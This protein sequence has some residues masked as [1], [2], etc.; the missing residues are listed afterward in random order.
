MSKQNFFIDYVRVKLSI[1][2]TPKN[3]EPNQTPS[4]AV[5]YLRFHATS[6]AIYIRAIIVAIT[7]IKPTLLFYVSSLSQSLCLLSP[8]SLPLSLPLS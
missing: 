1:Y 6:R 8:I 3:P 5:S 7:P 2:S 4:N